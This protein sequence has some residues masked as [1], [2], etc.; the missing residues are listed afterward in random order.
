M[1]IV[2]PVN[3]TMHLHLIIHMFQNVNLATLRPTNCVYIASQHPE[4]RP[5]SLSHRNF[6]S[7]FNSAILHVILS[8]GLDTCGSVF[9]TAKIL[10]FGYDGCFSISNNQVIGSASVVLKLIVSP[11]SVAETNFIVP[12]FFIQCC[13]TELLRPNQV[14][15]HL[16]M[17]CGV[18]YNE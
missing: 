5:Y 13:S 12:N 9:S 3:G 17:K 15:A 14:P 6:D 8:L 2:I 18:G 10:L 7:S 1:S 11:S 16:T 4:G